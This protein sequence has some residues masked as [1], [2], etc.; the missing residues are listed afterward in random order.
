MRSDTRQAS[1]CTTDGP[2]DQLVVNGHYIGLGMNSI[3]IV[4]ATSADREDLF[5]WRNDPVTQRVSKNSM[6]VQWET[7]VAWFQ[8]ALK[9]RDRSI[10]I[11]HSGAQKIGSVRFDRMAHEANTFL[12]SIMIASTQRGQGFGKDLL[13]AGI[14]MLPT[15][16]FKADIA[17]DNIAS[18]RIFEACGFVQV[19]RASEGEMLEYWLESTAS[20]SL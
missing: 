12:V 10:Y 13:G 8:A 16:A 9:S 11:G 3:T 5:A 6:P 18:Q 15:A 20:A 14:A 2:P 4:A 19:R 17:A 7:H 1:K